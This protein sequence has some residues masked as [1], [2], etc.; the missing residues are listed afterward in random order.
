MSDNK[1]A[2][3][4]GA[5]PAGLTAA[6]ELLQH[7]DYHPLILERSRVVGGISKTVEVDGYRID[8]GGHRFF[9]KS[10]RVQAWWMDHLPLEK[11]SESDGIELGYQGKRMTLDA[12]TGTAT[13]AHSDRV[14]LVRNRKS[15]IYFARTFFDYP[16]SLTPETLCKLGLTRTVRIASSYLMSWFRQ[17]SPE[18]TL[19][20]FF[21]NRFGREL[22]A[23]FFKSY[24]EKVWGV[25]C[26]EIC[27]DWGRQRIK[28]LSIA[29]AVWHSIKR[30][31]PSDMGIGQK[32]TE[33]SLIEKF[34]YP[35]Y[36][37]GQLWECVAE[38]IVADGGEIRFD[39]N[40]VDVKL[41]DSCVS[42]VT[43]ENASTGKREEIVGDVFFSTMAVRDLVSCIGDAAPSPVAEVAGGLVY[44]DF[45]VVGL[46]VDRLAVQG[47]DG[48]L[49]DDNWIYVQDSGVQLGRVQIFNNWSPY[50]LADPSKVWLGLEYFCTEGDAFWS[51]ADDQIA[52]IAVK[53]AAEIGI[54]S[55]EA[56]SRSY[57]I[58]ETKTYPAYFG[59]Y[60]RFDVVRDYFDQIDNLFLIGRNGMHRYNN[61]DHS[62][63]TAM[64][65]IENLRTGQ[66]SRENIWEVNT[67]QE[68]HEAETSAPGTKLTALEN[69]TKS[70]E[71]TD[72]GKVDRQTKHLED[73]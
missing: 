9:S 47:P 57:V 73:V 3:I 52:E 48:G 68:Y 36:G 16:L 49:I 62:M 53:E 70:Y 71:E 58:R 66:R 38:R 64:T 8:I 11:G 40:V 29:R 32:G 56:V 50:L 55:A 37:P 67:E 18:Q 72:A 19:A 5:G 6:S 14:M 27:A 24:T 25:P 60:D 51:L 1:V 33:T 44:R 12:G 10:S 23:T 46:L 22:Y 43:V 26:D 63:L 41:D 69:L 30:L 35:K 7:T 45:V 4:I 34:L 13:D 42:H 20:D 2:V 15:R 28:G 17:I 21:I 59:T 39:T 65:A 61:M 54:L 31:L